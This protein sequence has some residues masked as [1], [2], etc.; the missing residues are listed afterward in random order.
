[1]PDVFGQETPQEV[2]ARIRTGAVESRLA[3][4]E[5]AAGQSKGGQLGTSLGTIFGPTVSKAFQTRKD[6]KAETVRLMKDKGLSEEEAKGLA[7]E[8][9]KFGFSEV[10]QAQ[11]IQ[12]A[13]AEAEKVMSKISPVGGDLKAQAVG[14]L[15]MAKELRAAGDSAKAGQMSQEAAKLLQLDEERVLNLRKLKAEVRIEEKKVGITGTTSFRQNQ[16]QRELLIGKLSI[17]DNSDEEIERIQVQIGELDSKI[18]KDST[19]VGRTVQDIGND[20]VAMRKLFDDF[21]TD[22]ILLDGLDLAKLALNDLSNYE[23]SFLGRADAKFRGF[24]QDK[25]QIQPSETSKQFIDRVVAGQGIATLVA[26]KIRHS[27]TGAQMSQFEIEFLEPFLPAPGDSKQRMLA[28]IAAVEAYT[29][30]SAEIRL[31]MIQS[32]TLG[33]FF[34]GHQTAFKKNQQKNNQHVSRL[35]RANA[36]SLTI[37]GIIAAG[38]VEDELEEEE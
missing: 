35:D 4:S 2:L 7:K 33:Q 26:A 14:L 8:N 34:K 6:R 17:P 32:K 25:F 30:Q 15:M 16:L 23:A 37:E 1:M 38:T 9:I 20:P 36:A 3:F 21:T 10:R 13:S 18:E 24:L 12:K 5:T 19:I 22:L 31:G 29:Q 11:R 27:L 28:K